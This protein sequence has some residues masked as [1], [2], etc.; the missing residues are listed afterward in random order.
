MTSFIYLTKPEAE[1]LSK[2]LRRNR[3]D[4]VR[5]RRI[6]FALY[7]TAAASLGVIA[8]CQLGILDRLPELPLPYFDANKVTSSAEAYRL[9]SVPDAALGIANCGSTMMLVAM[10]PADRAR[11]FPLMPLLMA[12]KMTF[13]ALN[14]TRLAVSEWKKHRILCSWCLLAATATVIGLPLA[15][16]E[17]RAAWKQITRSSGKLL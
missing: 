8:A 16:R 9:L 6:I 3:D 14:A 13:D 12:G 17:S 2:S 1:Q 4:A 7:G 10:G 11:R 15:A 5:S